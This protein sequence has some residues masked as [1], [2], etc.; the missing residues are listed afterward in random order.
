MLI[1]IY[2]YF[3]IE[4]FCTFSDFWYFLK[5]I[6]ERCIESQKSF[7]NTSLTVF[8]RKCFFLGKIINP[9][10]TGKTSQ[11]FYSHSQKKTIEL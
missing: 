4:G 5:P 2:S 11:V 10:L 7:L 9:N 3:D 8:S 6:E 1:N